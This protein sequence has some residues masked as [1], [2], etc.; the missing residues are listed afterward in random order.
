MA[1]WN[2]VQYMKFE[3]ERTQP[4]VDLLNRLTDLAPKRILDL[5]CGPG[6]SSHALAGKFPAADIIGIDSSE[7]M[8]I[9][10]KAAYPQFSFVSCHVP[11]GLYRIDGTFDL[12]FSNACIHWIPD[13]RQLIRSVFEKL[14]PGGV[15]A[16]QL[17]MTEKA[18]F[19]RLLYQFIASGRWKKLNGIRNFH[20]L[21]P[22]EYDAL[23][24]EFSAS[25]S[26]WETIYYHTVPSPS[27]VLEWY[28]GSGLRP[29]LSALPDEERPLFLHDLEA[30]IAGHY[31]VKPSGS[32]ILKMPRLFF[33]A[34]K[35]K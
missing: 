1:D 34:R 27:A 12:V 29:Y 28:M 10:A 15:F 23:L 22:K 24:S 20:N 11:D 2:A 33:I 7:D 26:M 4:S 13:Q 16:V 25:L 3:S 14:S 21:S 17:P 5:G 18:L 19:Y 35:C 32:V 6:N 31:P 30:L 9:K 8:L